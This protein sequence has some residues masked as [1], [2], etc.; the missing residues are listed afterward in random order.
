[1]PNNA[2]TNT[3]NGREMAIL[4][5]TLPLSQKLPDG[6]Y[7]F[8]LTKPDADFPLY[9]K[10]FSVKDYPWLNNSIGK[11]DRLIVGFTPLKRNGSTLSAVLKDIELGENGLPATVTANGKTVLAR[12]VAVVA[13]T[14]G[15]PLEWRCQAPVF[16]GASVAAGLSVAGTS[17]SSGSVTARTLY[18]QS[19]SVYL[20]PSFL[21]AKTV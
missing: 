1:M 14:N 7:S 17:P 18:E 21:T 6:K 8:Y 10:N 2:P 15:E 12:P 19:S 3:V 20:P 11:A 16:T 5:Q 13:E 4:H 9:E